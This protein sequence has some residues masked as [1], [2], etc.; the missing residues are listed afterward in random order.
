MTR[1][2]PQPAQVAEVTTAFRLLQT[3][4]PGIIAFEDGVNDSP[5]E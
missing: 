1:A 4:I 5:E 2:G 3:T